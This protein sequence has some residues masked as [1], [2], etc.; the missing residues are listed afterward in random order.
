MRRH[1]PLALSC[2]ALFIALGGDATA[3]SVYS[4]ATKLIGGDQIRKGAIRERHLS[5]SV[6]AKLAKAGKPGPAGQD[7]APGAAGPSGLAGQKGEPGAAGAQGDAGP[8][9]SIAGAAAGGALTGS[10]PNPGLADD[11]VTADNVASNTLGGTEIDESQLGPVP[12]AAAL[13]G[14]PGGNYQQECAKGVIQGH[15][16]IFIANASHTD[17]ATTG[18]Q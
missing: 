3:T 2:L 12:N 6:R 18:V 1:L 5:R 11:I 16:E 17:Y 13:A 4:S 10:Y 9:G 7:G 15:A 14:I 8:P